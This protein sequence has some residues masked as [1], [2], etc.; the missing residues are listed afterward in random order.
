V[1]TGEVPASSGS[2]SVGGVELVGA[3]GLRVAELRRH[4][5]GLV[6]QRSGRT[7]RPELDVV[8]N[9]ALQLRLAGAP[10]RAAKDAARDA[11][12]TL[13]LSDLAE[14]RPSTLSAGEA[15]RV[16][17]CAAIAHRPSVL[18][19]DEPTGELD[20]TTGNQ[21]ISLIDRLHRDGMAVVVVT[22]DLAVAARAQRLLRMRDGQIVEEAA[23]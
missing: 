20:Q 1:L 22:H 8:D 14:R 13:G 11:L 16:A 12:E 2:V 23:P 5:L 7:L 9:V 6:D 17:V 18:L 3:G 15:Q 4:V 21:I 19:A 10:K